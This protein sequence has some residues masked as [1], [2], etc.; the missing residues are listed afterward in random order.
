MRRARLSPA[1]CNQ[2]FRV[3]AALFGR[4]LCNS[5]CHLGRRLNLTSSFS[6]GKARA[7]VKLR[8]KPEA[9]ATLLAGQPTTTATPSW[10]TNRLQIAESLQQKQIS[11]FVSRSCS[12]CG[13]CLLASVAKSE[14]Q[15]WPQRSELQSRELNLGNSSRE[16]KVK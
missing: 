16:P 10:P 7:D 12:A 9:S 8:P 6:E 11:L 5:S 4:N 14:L 1:I 2:S 13:G 3:F 15:F